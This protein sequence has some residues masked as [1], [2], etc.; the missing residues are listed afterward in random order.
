MAYQMISPLIPCLNSLDD[1]FRHLAL[2]WT[3]PPNTTHKPMAKPKNNTY[4]A[5]SNQHVDWIDF[6]P[7]V[8]LVYNT[9]HD[10][11]GATPLFCKLRFPSSLQHFR[12]LDEEHAHIQHS[13]REGL[14][15]HPHLCKM[16]SWRVWSWQDTLMSYVSLTTKYRLMER[17]SHNRNWSNN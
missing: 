16:W 17:I 8:E 6:L 15:L 1:S 2:L 13:V 9:L 3:F 7:M 10:S 14:P 4:G 5:L 11:M 12:M